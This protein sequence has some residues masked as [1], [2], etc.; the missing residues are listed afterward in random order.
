MDIWAD[1]D[2]CPGSH[3]GDSISCCPAHRLQLTLVAATG[4]TEYQHPYAAGPSQVLMWA[5]DEIVK[6]VPLPATW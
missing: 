4:A 3:Q 6:L 1:A 5:D 2:A